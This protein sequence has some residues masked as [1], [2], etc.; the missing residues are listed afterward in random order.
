MYSIARPIIIYPNLYFWFENVPS[1]NPDSVR[2]FSDLFTK[3]FFLSFFF[4]KSYSTSADVGSL[5]WHQL[6][7]LVNHWEFFLFP[8]KCKNY[9][10]RHKRRRQQQFWRWS[11]ATGNIKM[12]NV[13]LIVYLK[14][15]MMWNR[16]SKC[17]EHWFQRF[18][19]RF[20]AKKMT[21][22]LNKTMLWYNFCIN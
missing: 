1:G 7:S 5:W 4:G 11:H 20:S 21:F 10:F 16:W 15:S 17:G 2:T 18:F 22:F 14:F 6:D 9:F 3:V 8:Q 13:K 19:Y 12:S